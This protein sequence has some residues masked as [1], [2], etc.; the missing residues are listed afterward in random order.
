MLIK[1]LLVLQNVFG[2]PIVL[3]SVA[4]FLLGMAYLISLSENK[5]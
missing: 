4:L 1:G 3:S 5:K 2:T